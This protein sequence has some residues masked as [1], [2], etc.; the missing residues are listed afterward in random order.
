[1]EARRAAKMKQAGDKLRRADEVVAEAAAAAA[2]AAE[3]GEDESGE[4]AKQVARTA[5]LNVLSQLDVVAQVAAADAEVDLIVESAVDVDETAAAVRA[6][7][8]AQ[9]LSMQDVSNALESEKERQGVAAE[10]KRRERQ[11]AA[12]DRASKLDQASRANAAREAAAKEQFSTAQAKLTDNTMVSYAA[13]VQTTSLK[14][15]EELLVK[16]RAEQEHI[17]KR[18]AS[19]SPEEGASCL[20][21]EW[22][23]LEEDCA[24]LAA[25]IAK[26]KDAGFDREDLSPGEKEVKLRKAKEASW[27]AAFLRYDTDGSGTISNT[28][29]CPQLFALN[30]LPSTD[31]TAQAPSP[32]TSW[33]PP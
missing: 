5:S 26:D 17:K 27:R 19:T 14:M 3:A 20:Q 13:H 28:T 8:E 23:V 10:A 18:M 15:N 29:V 1:M 16:R 2:E 32:W 30:C 12:K 21:A 4:G 33:R 31:M 9:N 6:M 7:L 22:D 24:K 11:G 25:A